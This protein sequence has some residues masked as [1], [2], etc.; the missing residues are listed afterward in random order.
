M[1]EI[2]NTIIELVVLVMLIFLVHLNADIRFILEACTIYLAV[3]IRHEFN[4]KR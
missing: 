1:G 4:R 2:I 3:V